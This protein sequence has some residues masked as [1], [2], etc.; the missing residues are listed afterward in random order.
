LIIGEYEH[1]ILLAYLEQEQKYRLNNRGCIYA[2][3][4]TEI[5]DYSTRNL[6]IDIAGH[7][8]PMGELVGYPLSSS[9]LMKDERNVMALTVCC[10][11]L[12]VCENYFTTVV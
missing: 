10:C 7:Q 3:L 11:R 8:L 1:R 4:G 9:S 6:Q 12:Q 2:E 5:G